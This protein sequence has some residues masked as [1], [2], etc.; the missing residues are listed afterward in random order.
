MPNIMSIEKKKENRKQQVRRLSEASEVNY[1]TRKVQFRYNYV[2]CMSMVSRP[3]KQ[4]L[5]KNAKRN[6]Y[7]C[8]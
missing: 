2:L 7:I 4:K 5:L 1:S 6:N 8:H 3:Q